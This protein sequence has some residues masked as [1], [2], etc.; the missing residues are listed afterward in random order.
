MI[1]PRWVCVM[2]EKVRHG[3]PPQPRRQDQNGARPV[4]RYLP[5]ARALRKEILRTA[6][7]WRPVRGCRVAPGE[8]EIAPRPASGLCAATPSATGCRRCPEKR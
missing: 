2:W 7:V 6:L 3:S 1:V 4:I 5:S 8:F